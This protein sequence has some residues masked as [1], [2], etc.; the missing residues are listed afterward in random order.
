MESDS[1][2]SRFIGESSGAA[3]P[4]RNNGLVS[5]LCIYRP[6]GGVVSHELSL[7][8]EVAERCCRTSGAVGNSFWRKK[9]PSIVWKNV[10]ESVKART[11]P[12]TR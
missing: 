4:I 8:N 2:G 12:F 11:R 7:I 3:E 1:V 5:I 10:G 9:N 6:D